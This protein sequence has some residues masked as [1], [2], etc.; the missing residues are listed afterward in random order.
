[1]TTETIHMNKSSGKIQAIHN[2]KMIN[3][4]IYQNLKSEKLYLDIVV[5][6]Y[7]EENSSSI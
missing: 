2:R 3:V 6:S 1:M 5:K 4:E 7:F